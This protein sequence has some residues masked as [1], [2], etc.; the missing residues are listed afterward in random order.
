MKHVKH[1]MWPEQWHP[2]LLLCIADNE[3]ESVTQREKGFVSCRE[4]YVMSLT[5]R[6]FEI[7]SPKR[8]LNNQCSGSLLRLLE[9]ERELL[10]HWLHGCICTCFLNSIIK[11]Y[12]KAL[13]KK[14]GEQSWPW[15]FYW[16]EQVA[17]CLIQF[18]V[19]L[20]GPVTPGCVQHIEIWFVSTGFI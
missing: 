3:D 6:R 1:N 18:M 8:P 9:L 5:F 14:N 10:L 17:G 20:R 2:M 15:M 4:E 7:T 13:P 12:F 16:N 11:D 19:T